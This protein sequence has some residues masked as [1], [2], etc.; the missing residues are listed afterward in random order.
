MD[1]GCFHPFKYN[2]TYMLHKRG[3]S[4]LNVDI[5]SIKIEGFNMVRSKDV[6]VVS[7]VSDQEADTEFYSSGFYS[8]TNTLD[9]DF[10]ETG[11]GYKP[12]KVK[13]RKLSSILDSSRFKD[14]QIDFLTVDAEAHDINVL[15]SLD[16]E[17][18]QPKTIAVESHFRALE[19][20]LNDEVYLFLIEQGYEMINWVG[21]TVLY[22]HNSYKL[23]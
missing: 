6:N 15:R 20:V 8:L 5:D 2:N 17:R 10:S 19:E 12:I 14:Q 23:P 18:Y 3:W 7:A 13:T 11:K 22:R 1:V 4:G 16:F 9:K 21:L